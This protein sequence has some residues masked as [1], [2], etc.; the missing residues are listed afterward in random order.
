MTSA[1]AADTPHPP[2]SRRKERLLR[3]GLLVTA[4][5]VFLYVPPRWADWNQNSRMD[6]TLAIAREGRVE[7]D[8][9]HE[10]TGYKAFVRGHYYTDQSIGVSLLALPVAAVMDGITATPPLAASL[11]RYAAAAGFRDTLRPGGTGVA[12]DKVRYFVALYAA[13]AFAVTLPS[14]LLVGVLFSTLRPFLPAPEA[15]LLLTLFYAVGTPALAYSASLYG[16][17]PA[18]AALFAAFSLLFAGGDPAPVSRRRVAVAGFLLG[19]AAL[20][21][22]SALVA[23]LPLL[24]YMARRSAHPQ[25]ASAGFLSALLPFAAQMAYNAR[26]FGSPLD[27]GYRYTEVFRKL[28][29]AV[30]FPTLE[31]VYGIAFSPFRGIFFRSPLLLLSAWGFVLWRRDG[32]WRDAWSVCAAVPLLYFAYNAFVP[33]WWG[34]SAVGPRHIVPALPFLLPPLAMS[35]QQW[36]YAETVTDGQRRQRLLLFG[37]AAALG[38]FLCIGETWAGQLFPPDFPRTTWWDVTVPQWQRGNIARNVGMALG[39]RGAASLLPLIVLL[40]VLWGVIALRLK[41]SAGF[42]AA[43]H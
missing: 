19:C 31:A 22:Y 2:D 4:L 6:L 10:N 38:A 27:T 39:L 26:A 14:V 32:R 17:L 37:V 33:I 36:V 16:H 15:R 7:I 12:V 1:T 23:V 28:P 35:I 29:V 43:D 21:E 25:A 8:T 9:L 18:A 30:R 3:R 13:T 24:W 20:L 40:T 11:A 41:N 42:H 34:G 5:L